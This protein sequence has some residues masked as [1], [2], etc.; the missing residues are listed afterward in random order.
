MGNPVMHWQI[1][2][3]DPERLEEFYSSLF[4]WT[5]SGDN[6]LG[7]KMIE[8]NAGEGINGGVWPISPNEGHTMVQLFV[9]VNDLLDHV[10]QA[11]SLGARI[12]IPP[13]KLPG[14]DEMAVLTDPDGLPFVMFKGSGNVPT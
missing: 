9:R 12:V 4:G 3:K 8:T 5:F 11:E 10:R 2:T 7:Y 6:P 14:G 1:L 13:Q